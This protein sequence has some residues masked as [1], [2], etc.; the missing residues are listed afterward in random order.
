[1][2][3]NN[4]I[5]LP[6]HE[7]LLNNG[8][9]LK[10]EK[11][12]ITSKT[13]TNE[14]NDLVVVNKLPN[15]DYVYF[16]PNSDDRGNI[17]NFAKNRSI[18]VE[19]LIKA[20]ISQSYSYNDIQA[21][22]ENKIINQQEI[23]K[24]QSL[25]R[26]PVNNYFVEKRKINPSIL[27]NFTQIKTDNYENVNIPTYIIKHNEMANK[28]IL[29]LAGYVSYLKE[30]IKISPNGEVYD[31]PL[32]QLCRGVKG[33]EILNQADKADIKN[34]IIAESSIDSLSAL[35]IKGFNP[36]QTLLCA[37]NGSITKS[38][39][40]VFDY[41]A[42]EFKEAKVYC[43]F[44]NDKAGIDFYN[45]AKEHFEGAL[46]LKPVLKDFNDDLI[47]AKTL[48]IKPNELDKKAILDKITDI[49]KKAHYF[50][51]KHSILTPFGKEQSLKELREGYKLYTSIKPKISNSINLND[52][53]KSFNE[54]IN[55]TN[56]QNSQTR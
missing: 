24:F 20:D 51:N 32:K 11:C 34:I 44:D 6:L 30:P 46:L 19:D 4:P 39:K 45:K 40:E 13:L 37:T 27:N 35:E 55:I 36:Q 33:L 21:K 5:K 25:P 48:K 53:E 22:S 42:K 54:I 29:A 2:K 17:Y 9:W 47:V 3:E 26:L 7:I 1:M 50:I 14:N 43:A 28:E 52:I 23:K 18:K 38:H 15:N 41:L 10:K 12:T 49:D 56:K 16:K 8:W 31:K